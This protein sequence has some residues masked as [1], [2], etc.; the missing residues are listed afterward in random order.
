MSTVKRYIPK[1]AE[2]VAIKVIP[3]PKGETGP[4]G[5][6]G[7]Q[8]IQ[9]P[10]GPAGPE[11]TA[12][13]TGPQGSQGPAG[14]AGEDGLSAYEVAVANGFEGTEE[15]WLDSLNNCAIAFAIALG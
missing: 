7:P 8:G 14:A 12:G 4:M 2:D 10:I 15:E 11:G 6:I 1:K 9:G 13:A 5:P 3:G